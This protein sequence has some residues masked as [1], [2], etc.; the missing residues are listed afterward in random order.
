MNQRKLMLLIHFLSLLHFVFCHENFKSWYDIISNP[1]KDCTLDGDAHNDAL[2]EH[3]GPIL[4]VS[5][6]DCME[7][8][9]FRWDF[10][11]DGE[12]KLSKKNKELNGLA[13]VY[14]DKVHKDGMKYG[15]CIRTYRKDIDSI[16]GTFVKNQL[17]GKVRIHFKNG[18]F[19]AG[20]AKNS[21]FIGPI[22]YFS[23]NLLLSNMTYN[24]LVIQVDESTGVLLIRDGRDGGYIIY[25][26]LTSM[27]KCKKCNYTSYIYYG[28]QEIDIKFKSTSSCSIEIESIKSTNDKREFVWNVLTDQRHF[29]NDDIL[30]SCENSWIYGS[31]AKN[32]LSD[33][34]DQLEGIYPDPYWRMPIYKEKFIN[35]NRPSFSINIPEWNRDILLHEFEIRTSIQNFGQIKNNHGNFE[36]NF[37][38][39][40]FDVQ[41]N[42][43]PIMV[44]STQSN[45]VDP[46]IHFEEGNND[47][48]KLITSTKTFIYG[49]LKNGKYH[50]IVRRFGK[51]VTDP[52]HLCN[53][54][55]FP[56]LAFIGRYDNGIPVGPS[57]RV[58]P[59]GGLLYGDINGAEFT[60]DNLAYIYPDLDTVIIGKFKKGILIEGK[61]ATLTGVRCVN[62]IYEARFSEPEGPS[63]H[64]L[65]ATNETYG[66]QPMLTDPLDKKY[67]YL[68]KS[69]VDHEL[70]DQGV[71]ASRDIPKHT[72]IALYN[73]IVLRKSELDPYNQ[74]C[75]DENNKKGIDLNSDE[76]HA[77]YKY[78]ASLRICHFTII[79]PIND[80]ST[81]KYNATL[82]HK[83]NHSFEPNCEFGGILD[84]PRFGLIR[85]FPTIRDIKK[86]EELFISYGYREDG[87]PPWYKSLYEEKFKKKKN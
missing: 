31:K 83:F 27:K 20:Y 10:S 60:G 45:F 15:I 84:T 86:G 4:E 82:A 14:F 34:L 43:L 73:G 24:K 5:L 41:D 28:C 47:D 57:W 56:G 33:W 72:T 49:Q 64:Y 22:R 68:K 9:D 25:K 44:V 80:G 18:E 69:N 85:S 55:S 70:A 35:K 40:E 53:S 17:Q 26:D 62:G 29:E 16:G 54:T 12:K 21:M 50:G 66:D 8:N 61:E 58:V 3:G 63:Y 81:E 1:N 59:G 65:P 67:Y 6:E 36:F 30:P 7:G 38:S 32:Q 87:A 74:R 13:K 71:F 76:W 52:K 42:Q 23:S 39:N 79:I 19:I 78:H 11:Y 48:I 2:S 46:G 37:R 75:K 77:Y 51:Y